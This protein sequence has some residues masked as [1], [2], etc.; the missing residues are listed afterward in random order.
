MTLCAP[1]ARGE[2]DEVA[3]DELVLAVGVAQ[4]G[5]AGQDEQP[6]LLDAL[7]V[8]RA[9]AVARIELVERAAELRGADALAEPRIGAVAGRGGGS[10]STASS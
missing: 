3:A 7:V 8:V 2:A 5:R 4:G 10:P 1:G 6:F 9:D